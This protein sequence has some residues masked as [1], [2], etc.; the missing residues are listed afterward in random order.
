MELNRQRNILL[1]DE[2]ITRQE[3]V[4]ALGSLKGKAAPGK[5]GLVTEMI[6]NV[7]LVD[8]WYKLFKLY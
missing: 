6:N 2:E 4:W 7:I 3:L 5:D 1:L 8:F